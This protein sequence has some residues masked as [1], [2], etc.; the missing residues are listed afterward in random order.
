MVTVEICVDSGLLATSNCPNKVRRVYQKGN[1]PTEYCNIHNGSPT[2]QKHTVPGVV[3]MGGS[4]AIASLQSAGFT[5][6]ESH[7]YGTAAAGTVQSQSPGGGSQADAGSSVSIVICDGAK[8][9]GSVPG[10]M[11]MS[12]TAA[13]TAIQN[14]GFKPSVNYVIDPTHVGIVIDQHPGGG[15]TATPGSTV[16][17]LVGKAGP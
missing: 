9:Q 2:P 10:V 12:E 8:P 15:S 4:S 17:I 14:A 1:E 6:Q 16:Y 7:A 5:V 13:V 3:G 11:G